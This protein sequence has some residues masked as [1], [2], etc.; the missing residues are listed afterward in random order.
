MPTKL[1]H[2]QFTAR[3]KQRNKDNPPVYLD[4]TDQ[5]YVNQTSNMIFRCKHNHI[6]TAPAGRTVF[7]LK[8]AGCPRCKLIND[9]KHKRNTAC[10]IK[11][12]VRHIHGNSYDL[13]L[14][15]SVSVKDNIK[16]KCAQHGVFYIVLGDVLYHN[17]GCQ[18][19]ATDKIKLA[20]L[21]SFVERSSIIH[22][23]KYDYSEVVDTH[24]PKVTIICP[25]HGRFKQ[26]TNDH[27]KGHGCRKC[28]DSKCSNK[29][30]IWLE[31]IMAT[32][33]IDIQHAY[34]GGEYLIP[35]TRYK[36]DGYC[37][38][39]NTIYEFYG[40]VFHGN[41]NNIDPN[42]QCHPFNN[43][44]AQQLYDH[45]CN[46]EQQLLN[47]GYNVI[48]IWESDFDKL[49]TTHTTNLGGM[50]KPYAHTSPSDV[51]STLHITLQDKQFKG[52]KH[53]HNFNCLT[54]G[55]NFISTLTQRKQANTKYNSVGC[56]ACNKS[57]PNT[58]ILNE[59]LDCLSHNEVVIKGNTLITESVVVIL[60]NTDKP[61][62]R[63]YL[64]DI[65]KHF[66]G[67][68]TF[69]IFVDEWVSNKQLVKLKLNHYMN[70]NTCIRIHGRRCVIEQIQP[71]QKSQFLIQNHIQG[72]DKAQQCYGAFHN[73]ELVSVMTF[74]KPRVALGY[75][76]KVRS[77]YDRMWELS[78]FAT[79]NKYRVPGIA[80]KLLKRF[81]LDNP[82]CNQI[83]SYADKRWSDGNLYTKLGFTLMANNSPDYFY[84]INNKR[85][86]RWNYRK[87]MLKKTLPNYDPN[88]TEHQ[89]MVNHGFWRV[90][91]LG[92]LKYQID[93]N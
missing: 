27:L 62:E 91:D 8:P 87:D 51:L 59:I 63:T 75:K 68:R 31:H 56:P 34:S 37:S 12:R 15:K 33:D 30:I 47:F 90:W 5:Q 78:R 4:P 50:F 22:S 48:S 3:L 42:K 7:K 11:Q 46:R 2:N 92:T 28:V 83:F 24:K 61:L 76:N 67:K 89:N 72:N 82:Q 73:N 77:T 32:D 84:V 70:N 35:N 16:L 74:T 49:N 81:I 39:T 80:S 88:L 58:I 44:T 14:I 66:T 13:S 57:K 20:N 21:H 38:E 93:V 40:D 71:K 41:L 9:S 19:C 10:E 53:K 18:Q 23:S 64:I 25:T 54:C 17:R 36:A 26:K 79:D 86:H 52:F 43:L 60:V 69:F 85:K 65:K 6:W 45:T 1:T 55:N 29:Q